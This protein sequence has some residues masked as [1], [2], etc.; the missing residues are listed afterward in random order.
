MKAIYA[1]LLLYVFSLFNIN[2]CQ[3]QIFAKARM[4]LDSLYPNAII[5]NMWIASEHSITQEVEIKCN[6]QEFSGK[7]IIKIDTSG[8]LLNKDLYYDSLTSL[9]DTIVSY[10]K[11]NISQINRI[12]NS[13]MVKS[14]NNKGEV[15][16]SIKMLERS[17]SAYRALTTYIIKFKSSGEIISKTPVILKL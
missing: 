3:S 1:F 12:D 4:K 15:S 7:M 6:C 11:N 8:N 10:I 17:T 9:P 13:Y 16:Y 14:I 5:G 2:Y